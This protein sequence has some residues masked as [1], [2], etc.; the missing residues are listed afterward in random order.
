[1]GGYVDL[2]TTPLPGWPTTFNPKKLA[3]AV[4]LPNTAADINISYHL[5]PTQ[6]LPLVDGLRDMP[7]I[8]NAMANLI[9]PYLR[10]L[11]NLG[12]EY[13]K[14]ANHLQGTVWSASSVPRTGVQRA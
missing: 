2:H 13:A 11:I 6:N 7:S 9:Q 12:Y 10:V 5:V 14:P 3:D 8:G 1:M 4:Q